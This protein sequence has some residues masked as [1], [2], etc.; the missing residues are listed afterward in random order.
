[1]D[2]ADRFRAVD[3]DTGWQLTDRLRLDFPTFHPQGLA[4]AANRI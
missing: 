1:M 4:I 3:R 2:L